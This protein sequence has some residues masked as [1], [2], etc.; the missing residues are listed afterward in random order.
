MGNKARLGVFCLMGLAI[1]LARLIEVQYQPERLS[2]VEASPARIEQ[3][4]PAAKQAVAQQVIASPAAPA[5]NPSPAPRERTYT[6][7]PGETL[8]KISQRV[9]GTRRH[10]RLIRDAN[11]DRIPDPRRMRAG[12]ELRIP[13]LPRKTK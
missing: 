13:A 12:V 1:A 11:T 9:Y 7:K 5:I 6:V 2:V 4:A 8:D 3:P 10:W